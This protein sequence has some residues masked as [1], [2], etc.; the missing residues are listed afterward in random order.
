MKLLSQ[1]GAKVERNG[2]VW[3]DAGPVNVFCAPVRF[4]ENHT[5]FHLGAGL[6]VA[7][8]G[9]GQV[10]LPGGCYRRVRS[11]CTLP[12]RNSWVRKS[13]WKKAMKASVNGRLKGAH[14]DG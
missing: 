5:R 9:Q 13:N 7:R 11:T 14:R 3:I 1:L 2:S 4:S 6:L 8:F 12:A 10:S